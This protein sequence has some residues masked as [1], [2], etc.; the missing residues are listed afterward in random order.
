MRNR[1]VIAT[2]VAVVAVAVVALFIEVDITVAAGFVRPTVRR[3]A[4]GDGVVT[5]V[6][7]FAEHNI[8]HAVATVWQSARRATERVGRQR[9]GGAFVTRF[10]QRRIDDMITTARQLTVALAAVAIDEIAIVALLANGWVEHPVAAGFDRFAI[11]AATVAIVLIAIVAK[12]V[13]INPVIAACNGQARATT[14][15]TGCVFGRR[16]GCLRR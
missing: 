7:F 9:I 3:A 16:A 15:V 1:A 13:Q 11:C 8:D 2:T 12:L 4:V 14:A 6:A 5:V 10:I